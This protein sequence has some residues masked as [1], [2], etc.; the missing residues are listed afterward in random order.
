MELVGWRND[1][2]AALVTEDR[3]NVDDTLYRLSKHPGVKRKMS[4]LRKYMD[5]R[6]EP[7]YATG[8]AICEFSNVHPNYLSGLRET[9]GRFPRLAS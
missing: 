9:R 8:V 1:R 7:R 5:G 4:T 3:G 2:F 6:S